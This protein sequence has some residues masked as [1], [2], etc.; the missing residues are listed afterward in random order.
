MFDPAKLNQFPTLPG[1]YLMKREDGEILY[2]GKAKNLKARLKQYFLKGGD[3]RYMI[4]YLVPQIAQIDTIVVTSEKEALILENN[5]IKRHQP[6][7]NALLKDDKAFISLK[8]TTKQMW[9]KVEIVRSRTKPKQDGL[10]FG[11]YTSA[12]AARQTLDLIQKMFPLR[13]CSDQELLRRTRPCIL[14]EMKRCIA[15]CVG[16][17]TP[18]EYQ[19]E[20][21]N[22]IKFLRGQGKEV[23]N[24]LKDA[25]ETASE[26]MEF[27]RAQALLNTIRQIEKTLEVQKVHKP[28]GGSF[29]ALGIYRHGDEVY[30][31]QL[32]VIDGKLIA[33]LI[34]H[35]K[36][37]LEED[38]ELVTSFILQHYQTLDEKPNE[39]LLP[40]FLEDKE[41][42]EE[43]VGVPLHTPQKGEKKAFIEM[44]HVNAKTAFE[45]EKDADRVKEQALVELQ[46]KLSLTRFPHVIECIDN[47]NLSGSEPVSALVSYVDGNKEKNRYRKYKIK[48]ADLSDDYGMMQ[49]VLSRRYRKAKEENNLPDLL[50]IDGGKGHLNI[51]L[52]VLET[53][54]IVSIDV[55][56][57]AKDEGRHDK[58]VTQEQV[59]TPNVKDPIFF[60]HHSPALFLIQRI[61]DEAHRFAISFQK[62]RRSKALVRSL[63]DD[64][65]GIGPAKRK[66]LLTHFGSLKKIGEATPEELRQVKGIHAKDVEALQKFFG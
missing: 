26:E 37:I 57:V 13:Q 45:K 5:L 55:I 49:E 46:E 44:A 11:P 30:L 40:V 16:K 56:G 63:L 43:I 7:Y 15:P 19:S 35:F 53:L 36:K 66:A 3:G 41:A 51:A 27:E 34:R 21:D 25:M 47:S 9:P 38:G 59:F 12:Y 64:I 17:C 10:Y 50:I 2:V 28:F 4:P 39:I 14:Y 23:I 60:K 42:L 29:D 54:D 1:V 58:G 33:S 6:H 8:V 65:P 24:K 52:K 61:R 20:V 18:E 22:T 62:N 31:S 32:K 48:T